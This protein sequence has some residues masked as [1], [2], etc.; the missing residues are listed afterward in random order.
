MECRFQNTD[1]DLHSGASRG[2]E[3]ADRS[4][5][6]TAE[7]SQDRPTEERC[8]GAQG[9]R[10]II[11]SVQHHGSLLGQRIFRLDQFVEF[12]L[13]PVGLDFRTGDERADTG[14]DPDLI[15]TAIKSACRMIV[16]W[17]S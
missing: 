12:V 4:E 3:L 7:K 1:K 8:F 17:N 16:A 14:Q 2:I 13:Q 5:H 9:G 11:V 15:E 10:R 6:S